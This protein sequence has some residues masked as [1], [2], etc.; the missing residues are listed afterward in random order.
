MPPEDKREED[1]LEEEEHRKVDKRA[2]RDVTAEPAKEEAAEEPEEEAG[3]PAEGP[4][5]EGDGTESGP[6]EPAMAEEQEAAPEA[7]QEAAA[8]EITVYGLLRMS[9][10]MYAQQAW[11]HMGLRMDPSTQKTEQNMPLAKVAIDTVAF[12]VEQLQ[13]DL[14]PE[15]KRELDSLVADL[16][17]NYVQQS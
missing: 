8:P 5:P 9:V 2:S 15:E 13:P 1:E 6:G 7:E 17:I 4:E 11:I 12:V 16:R 14:T 3:E 10:G